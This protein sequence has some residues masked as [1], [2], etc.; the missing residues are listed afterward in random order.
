MHNNL[1]SL[2]FKITFFLF[3]AGN[4]CHPEEFQRIVNFLRSKVALKNKNLS[5]KEQQQKALILAETFIK[6][7]NSITKL[8]KRTMKM[9]DEFE[10]ANV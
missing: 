2:S 4:N 3:P 9:L 5:T 6:S 8:D 10:K 1:F 7:N